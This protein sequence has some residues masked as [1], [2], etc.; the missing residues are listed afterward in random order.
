MAILRFTKWQGTGNDFI[1]VDD[2]D[3][4]CPSPE[5]GWVQRVC[6][7][8]WGIGSDG[9][10]LVQAP[11]GAGEDF[12][13]DFLNPDGSR[14]FCGN[15]SRCAAAFFAHLI[16]AG[17]G[18][19]FV[20]SAFDG[21]HQAWLERDRVVVGMRDVAAPVGVEGQA[22]LLDTGSP[23]LV[24]W[25]DDPERVDLAREGRALRNDP[26]FAPGGVNVNFVRWRDGRLEMRTYERG[27]EDET[28]SCGTGVTAA[29]LS[30]MHRGV[31]QGTCPVS[32][33]GGALEVSASPSGDGFIHVRLA[34]PARPVFEGIIT[35]D[36]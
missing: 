32:T 1:V 7:R 35:L 33:P 13:M 2:R 14:S 6:D 5:S 34:G 22:D 8:H 19:S 36:R 21:V 18:R 25:V 9:L 26:R 24:C 3:G 10:I 12:H 17:P 23:H 20:F 4:A 16:G 28:L 30:A 15:G 11:R 31:V 29:A 27:V